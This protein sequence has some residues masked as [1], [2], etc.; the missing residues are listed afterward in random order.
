ML[1]SH[2]TRSDRPGRLDDLDWDAK[3]CYRAVR[4]IPYLARPAGPTVHDPMNERRRRILSALAARLSRVRGNM[5]DAEFGQLLAD[6]VEMAE[7]F[8]EIDA[9]PN[10]SAPA[11]PP[12][13]IARLLSIR[14]E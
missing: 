12:D 4:A 13:E 6:M 7:R 9:K 8:A 1:G 2:D 3:L 14:L 10:A 5:T 11:M